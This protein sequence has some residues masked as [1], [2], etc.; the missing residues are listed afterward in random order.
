[1]RAG[2]DSQDLSVSHH[3]S[4]TRSHLINMSS[5]FTNPIVVRAEK[6]ISRKMSATKT[7]KDRNRLGIC[8]KY[9]HEFFI[10]WGDAIGGMVLVCRSIPVLDCLR[11]WRSKTRLS[12]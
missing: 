2:D 6:K 5:G 10:K 12:L 9:S 8:G 7:L 4:A 3:R 11:A 1:M